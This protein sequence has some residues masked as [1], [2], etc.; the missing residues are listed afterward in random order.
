M[1]GCHLLYATELIIGKRIGTVQDV[2]NSSPSCDVNL[3]IILN[4]WTASNCMYFLVC[5]QF[6]M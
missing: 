2:S 4:D 1:L 5:M 3:T 6:Q